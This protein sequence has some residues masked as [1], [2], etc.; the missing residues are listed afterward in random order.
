MLLASALNRGISPRGDFLCLGHWL[1]I[2]R[3][4]AVHMRSDEH[5]TLF[6]IYL[7]LFVVFTLCCRLEFR[8]MYDFHSR[9]RHITLQKQNDFPTEQTLSVFVAW[10]RK[11][12]IQLWT[13]IASCQ[14]LNSV[15]KFK[16]LFNC[17]GSIPCYLHDV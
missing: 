16:T 1:R 9:L 4:C 17:F 8:H 7:S 14:K 11:K 13:T 15:N 5:L 10:R 12:N 6:P 3:P 2:W